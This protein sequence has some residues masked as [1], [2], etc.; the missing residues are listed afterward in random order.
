MAREQLAAGIRG[1]DA[2]EF[3]AGARALIGL[4]EGLTPAGDDCLV[5]ALGAL[6]RFAPRSIGQRPVV[7]AELARAAAGGT[8]TIAREFIVHALEGRFSELVVATL[9]ASSPGDARRAA[10]RLV[11]TGATSGADTLTGLRL[12]LQA[13]SA[14]RS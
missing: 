4:G 6:W 12:A 14:T 11:D 8:T 1:D 3:L 13:L 9:M 10:T 7:R 5:G 2:D